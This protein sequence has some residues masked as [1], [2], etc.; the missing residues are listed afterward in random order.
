[1]QN[2]ILGQLVEI[3]S[4]KMDLRDDRKDTKWRVEIDAFCLATCPV[5]QVQYLAVMGENPSVFRADMNPVESVCW[6]DAVEFCNRLS[7]LNGLGAYYLIGDDVEV[8]GSG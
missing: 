4:G 1:M 2:D 6:L 8:T 5:T 3:P 7:E